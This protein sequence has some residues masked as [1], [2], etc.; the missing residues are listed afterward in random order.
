MDIQELDE[1]IDW[2]KSNILD[3]PKTREDI[4]SNVQ[5]ID[6]DTGSDLTTKSVKSEP[7]WA[8]MNAPAE[9]DFPLSLLEHILGL[10]RV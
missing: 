4:A 7:T 6:S 9:Y 1:F 8:E 2:V 10:D 5:V 3:M